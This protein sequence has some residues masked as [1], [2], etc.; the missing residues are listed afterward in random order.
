MAPQPITTTVSGNFCSS[1]DHTWTPLASG[2]TSAPCRGDTRSGSGSSTR[3]G[4]ATRS[5]NAPGRFMPKMPRSGQ[6]CT[7]PARQL[8]QRPHGMSEL[9]TT[10]SPI[11]NSVTSGATATISPQNSWPITSGGV[12]R[13][14]RAATASTS[15]PQMPTAATWSTASPAVGTGSSTVAISRTSQAG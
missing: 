2:S 14:L 11:L 5:A 8:A 4:A 13:G 12:R 6:R 10:R 15:E 7:A 9:A 3:A 1:R